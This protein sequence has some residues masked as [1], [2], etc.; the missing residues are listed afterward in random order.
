MRKK[1]MQHKRWITFV[2]ILLLVM[3]WCT[4]LTAYAAYPTKPIDY[5][6]LD[7]TV[8][9]GYA[10]NEVT[11]PLSSDFC[12]LVALQTGTS[13][14]IAST[15]GR[16]YLSFGV[17]HSTLYDLNLYPVSHRGLSLAD[18]PEGSRL[19]F[20]LF[21]SFT[22]VDLN[23]DGG[24]AYEPLER[25][26]Q[27]LH[28]LNTEGKQTGKTITKE[29]DGFSNEEITVAFDLDS[30]PT[31]ASSVVP[32]ITMED[33]M[34]DRGVQTC[35]ITLTNVSLVMDIPNGY[36]EQWV[37]EQNGQMI[38]NLG[39]R[40]EGSINDSTDRIEGAI[41]DSTDK[42]V[43]GTPEQDQI[44]NESNNEMSAAAGKLDNLGD[45]LNSVEKPDVGSM[46]VGINDLV[47]D[48]SSLLLL[49]SPIR[50]IW[51]NPV[52]LGFIT[53]VLTLVL[54]SWVFFGKK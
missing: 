22:Y 19:V 28:Y 53:I 13:S 12:R 52:A 20:D 21:I 51:Q 45:Q 30:F 26:S 4:P 32:Y 7:Y 39:D 42:I 37:V 15:Q 31:G 8:K 34:F 46:N 6:D 18:I 48:S 10:Y 25:L 3:A 17:D 1:V 43:N 16:D 11:V 2:V 44:A 14:A 9:E 24:T 49:T 33:F 35:D 54:V 47:G 27:K 23:D 38:D 50:E 40:I 29:I 36:W 41:T 5:R